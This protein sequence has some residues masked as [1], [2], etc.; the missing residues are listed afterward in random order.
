MRGHIIRMRWFRLRETP[1]TALGR[2]RKAGSRQKLQKYGSMG[3]RGPEARRPPPPLKNW[4]RSCQRG[5]CTSHRRSWR[6]RSYC[7]RLTVISMCGALC[8]VP[9]VYICPP[10]CALYVPCVCMYINCPDSL[11]YCHSFEMF[12][13]PVATCPSSSGAAQKPCSQV[14]LLQCNGSIKRLHLWIGCKHCVVRRGVWQI[15]WPC[16]VQHVYLQTLWG[17]GETK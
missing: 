17:G 5:T 9:A 15:F 16:V 1:G 2:L 4:R 12:I 14:P 3:S 7:I 10:V 8:T 6:G 11:L 13:K